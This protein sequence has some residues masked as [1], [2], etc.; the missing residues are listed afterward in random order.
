MIAQLRGKVVVLEKD[1]LVLD[2]G[3]VGFRVFVPSGTRS[4][5]GRVGEDVRLLTVM[6]VRE[7]FIGLYGFETTQER[8]LFNALCDVKG[9]GPKTA[10][11]IL[12]ALSPDRLALAIATGDIGALAQAPGVGKRTAE[13]LTVELKG[14]IGEIAPVD[15]ELTRGAGSCAETSPAGDAVNALVSLGYSSYEAERAV[16]LVI[17]E[18]VT[19]D[20]SQIIRAALGKMVKGE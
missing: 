15:T 17:S 2:V 12:S 13:R 7:D 9:I 1:A 16:G 18:G 5:L 3:G 20:A 11:G 8:E 6:I 4:S 10:M 19:D 14:R